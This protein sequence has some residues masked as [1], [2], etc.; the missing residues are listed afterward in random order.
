MNIDDIALTLHHGLGT[1]GI[2]WLLSVFGSA[3]GIFGASE[4]DLVDGARLRLELARG[5]LKKDFHSQAEKELRYMERN[6]LRGVASTDSEYPFLL[7][8]SADYPHVLYVKGD[9]GVLADRMLSMVGTRTATP[10]GQRMCDVLVG[11]MSELDGGL[12][13]VSG[14]AYGVDANCHRAALRYGLKTV[15]VIAN[16]LPDVTPAQH[17][18][19]AEEIVESGG[20]VITE[21]HSQTKQNGAYFIPRNRIIAGI[22]EGTVVV[23]SPASG[24]SLSTAEL[25]ESYN[26]TVMAVPGRAGDRCSEGANILIKR[27][28]AAMVTS[29]DDV[30]HEM[31]WDIAVPGRVPVGAAQA[32]LLSAAEKRVAECFAEGE[33]IDVDTLAMRSGTAPGELAGILL[34][35]EIGGVLRPLPGKIYEKI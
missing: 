19:L 24:G 8:E 17:R 3:E 6:S 22:S 2:V 23:E 5:L 18:S 26:R 12:C 15:A 9:A 14:L 34:S 16:P 30:F 29:G 1:R 28:R 32:P 35:L 20:A 10:Y 21:L 13:I 11:R 25:A 33:A 31:G 4:S 27:R 7:R